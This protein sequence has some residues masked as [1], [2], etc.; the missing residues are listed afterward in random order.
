[1]TDNVIP[2]PTA[3]P[4]EVHNHYLLW[5]RA[6]RYTGLFGPEKVVITHGL[7]KGQDGVI[8]LFAAHR[9][10]KHPRRDKRRA[11]LLLKLLK[12][13]AQRKAEAAERAVYGT[14]PW[15]NT[16]TLNWMRW[17]KDDLSA[18]KSL[19]TRYENFFKPPS[20][21]MTTRPRQGTVHITDILDNPGPGAA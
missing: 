4:T 2:L 15:T 9:E 14:A 8:K 18:Y 13:R 20:G 6:C 10:T 16:E 1:M 19:L 7:F 3:S 12:E 21:V 5:P 17:T 11:A